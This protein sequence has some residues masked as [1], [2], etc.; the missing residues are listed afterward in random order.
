MDA[1]RE[2]S[3][4][5]SVGN[6]RRNCTSI[7]TEKYLGSSILLLECAISDMLPSSPQVF[8]LPS[9]CGSCLIITSP[10]NVCDYSI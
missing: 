1:G 7:E 2:K 6:K 5:L 9:L 8:N 10:G 4:S 3:S